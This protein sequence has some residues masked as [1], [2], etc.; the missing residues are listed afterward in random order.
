MIQLL[1]LYYAFCKALDADKEVRVI[2]CDI[3]K[4]FDQVWHSGLIYKLRAAGMSGNLLDWFNS[5]LFKHRQRIVLLGVESIWTFIKAGVP[6]GSILGPLVF[7]RFINDIVNDIH[8]NIRLFADDTRLYLIVEHPDV[9][10]QLLNI[11]IETIA[12]WAKLW[13]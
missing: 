4:A 6:Q 2:F 13:L 5:Y 12:K 10:A 9:T 8:A 11:D 7:L 3:S 1:L